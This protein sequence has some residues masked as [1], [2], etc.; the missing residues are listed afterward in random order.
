MSAIA[1]LV[2]ADATPANKTLYPLSAS[3]A[4]CLYNERAANSVAG[5]RTADVR[6]SLASSRRKTDRITV[7]YASPKEAQVDGVW[8]VDSIARANVQ[9][10]IPVDWTETERNH[11]AAEV[12]SL[13]GT[14]AVKNTVKRD[15]G[16]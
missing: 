6:L 2:V 5:N 8:V 3:I 16:Y 9:Y 13:A 12:A 4:S 1:N 15:P 7:V 14:A 11:F 10:V